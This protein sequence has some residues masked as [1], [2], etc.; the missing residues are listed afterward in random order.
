MKCVVCKIGDTQP[1]KTTVTL[2]REQTVVVVEDVEALIC[3]NCG[4]YYLDSPTT[5]KVMDTLTDA[6]TRGTKLEILAMKA[7]A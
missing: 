2:R 1:G 4:H 5:K 6:I 3:N 7:A